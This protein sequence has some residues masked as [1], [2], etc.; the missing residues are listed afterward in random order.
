MILAIYTSLIVDGGIAQLLIHD[1]LLSFGRHPRRQLQS[2]A[3][4]A[5]SSRQSE[6]LYFSRWG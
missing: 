2:A 6:W 1:D 5:P 3:Q 4:V